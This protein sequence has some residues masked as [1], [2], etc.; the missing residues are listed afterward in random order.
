MFSTEEKS[1]TVVIGGGLAGLATAALL[2]RAGRNV[3]LVEQSHHLGGRAR[4]KVMDGFYF[5]MGPHAL[6]R[7]GAGSRVLRELG[8]QPRGAAPPVSG[9]FAI[10]GGVKQTF[11]AGLI[12][13]LTTGLFGLS[14]KLETARLLSSISK[15]DCTRVMNLSVREWVDKELSHEP[16]RE[17]ILATFRLATYTNAPDLMSA[18]TAIE[19]LQKA[20]AHGVLYLDRGWQTLVDKLSEVA[21]QAGVIIETGVRAESV[22]RGAGGQVEGVIFGDGRTCRASTVVLASTPAIASGLVRDGHQTS[23]ARWAERSI[24]VRA[25]CLDVALN[26]L[27]N[28][29]ARFALGIDA[30]L[31]LSV[32]SAAAELAPEGGALI[33]VA[34]YLPRDHRARPEDDERQLKELLDMIQ[35]GWREAVVHQ[36]FLPD[37]IVMNAIATAEGNGTSGR[38]GPAVHDV[39]GL[40]V[41][42]DWVGSVGLLADASLASARQ[43]ATMIIQSEA[44]VAAAG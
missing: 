33:Q 22:E 31:Y 3:R 13:L 27:P 20:L 15:I 4:T 38:P 39:P 41:A 11:P 35:P 1:D 19:Q 14:A 40:F 5:N 25:A 21:T 44:A 16:V 36:R 34:K 29:N 30:P 37:M 42:G 12:S 8:I 32:H 17:L 24:P 28:P 18:G 2:A 6:Y 9:G 10:K 26:R 23:L 43:A 7:S